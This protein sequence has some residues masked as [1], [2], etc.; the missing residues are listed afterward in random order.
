MVTE[1]AVTASVAN[2]PR[3]GLSR[4]SRLQCRLML[5]NTRSSS[6]TRPTTATFSPS[7]QAR[8]QN[9]NHRENLS[10]VGHQ[11]LEG[12]ALLQERLHLFPRLVAGQGFKRNLSQLQ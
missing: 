3:H 12:R 8:D 10:E 5:S 4:M 11:A 2:S 7:W 6:I 9:E 1:E